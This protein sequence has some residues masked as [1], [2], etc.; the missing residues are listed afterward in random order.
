MA[1]H[2]SELEYEKYKQTQKQLEKE[3]SLR[4]IEE[5]IK[6]LNVAKYLEHYCVMD[7]TQID[8]ADHT[9]F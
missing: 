9:S 5:D 8:K 7:G 4:E 2:K 3:Q 6:K 1:L